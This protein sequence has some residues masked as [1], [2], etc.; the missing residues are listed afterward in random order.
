[1]KKKI[2]WLVLGWC[3]FFAIWS[4]IGTSKKETVIEVAKKDYIITTQILWS[5]NAMTEI[6]KTGK[7]VWS[8]EIILSALTA[9][10]IH[11]IP[12]KIWNTVGQWTVLAYLSDTQWST[13]FR[14]K[15]AQVAIATAKN[16]YEI[17]RKNLEKQIADLQLAQ[18]RAQLS[19]D[20]TSGKT[21]N[22]TD[23]QLETIQK[24]IDK[25][26]A[27]YTTKVKSDNITIQNSI[28]SAKNIYADT[29]NLLVD[30]IEQSNT[31]LRVDEK[32]L[33]WQEY[34]YLGAKNIVL[35]WQ[36]ESDLEI[37]TA[38]KTALE[39]KGNTISQENIQEYLE[40]Y[41]T[42]LS[43][44]N[45][46]LTSIKEMIADSVEDSRYLPR[47]KIDGYVTLF[48]WLQ[49]KA[50]G[51]ISSTTS[52]INGLSTFLSLY[53]EQ[54]LSLQKQIEILEND[55]ALKSSQIKEGAQNTEISLDASNNNVSF[56]V[57]TKNLSLDS[58]NN[59]LRQAQI[60]LEEAN[61]AAAKLVVKSPIAWEVADVMV[62]VGQEVSPWVPLMK[63]VSQGK[64][65]DIVMSRE[66]LEWLLVWDSVQIENDTMKWEGVIVSIGS[67]AEKSGN[68]P[69]KLRVTQW[70]FS[71]G[72]FVDVVLSAKKSWVIVPLS[73]IK[74]VDNGVWQ[75]SLL[76]DNTIATKLVTLWEVFGDS[77]VIKD[78]LD[79]ES[80]II[81]SD[82]SNFDPTTMTLIHK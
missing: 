43:A 16:T 35:K 39:A 30:I 54:Q 36:V 34:I 21:G 48:W 82:I 25:A 15:N 52:Q 9:G 42:E 67:I 32:Q 58:I 37:L 23:L 24:N 12:T 69:V 46:F 60:A 27:D 7:V 79:V 66:E 78:P 65:I 50:S 11:S 62:D 80:V 49:T 38:R 10:K 61:F 59:S 4:F 33:R 55:L 64:D 72:T 41:K 22:N 76:E 28:T 20:N 68:F 5:G 73:S 44:M 75:I 81:T 29:K 45:I 18:K 17:Q 47:A 13:I 53:K 19:Y 56:A 63:I 77:V 2:V 3:G 71:I 70:D 31:L 8:S 57:D 1:M 6:R 26:Y 14:E 51:I 74:I 40:H